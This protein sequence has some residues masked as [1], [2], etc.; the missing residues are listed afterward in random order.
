MSLHLVHGAI[1]NNLWSAI[2][3]LSQSQ[4]LNLVV[5]GDGVPKHLGQIADSMS[6]WE[7]RIAD[8]L[9]LKNADVAAI[10]SEYPNKLRLQ[11]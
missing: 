5:D 6:E 7:G 8:E 9:G 11:M 2:G 4:V 3:G 10:K 1:I